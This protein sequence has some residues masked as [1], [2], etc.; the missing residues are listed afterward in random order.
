MYTDRR[1][2]KPISEEDV[3]K[4]PPWKAGELARRTGPSARA[5][6]HYDAIG[7]LK[8]SLHTPSGHRLYDRPDIER[9]QQI[10]SLRLMGISL[11]EVKRLLDGAAAS[12]ALSPRHVVE[13]HLARLHEQIAMSTR[14]AE[15]LTALATPNLLHRCTAIWDRNHRMYGI[16]V[17]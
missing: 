17:L 8:P 2:H 16:E 1:G 4:Q 13:L 10:Q 6:H 15:R 14:L 12:P 7:L 5:L 9:L 3:A 11:E